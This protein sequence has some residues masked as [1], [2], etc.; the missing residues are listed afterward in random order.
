MVGNEGVDDVIRTAGGLGSGK[1]LPKWRDRGFG[2]WPR[3]DQEYM[4]RLRIVNPVRLLCAGVS[5]IVVSISLL[6]F[7]D[8]T[9]RV[10]PVVAYGFGAFGVVVLCVGIWSIRKNQWRIRE[11]KLSDPKTK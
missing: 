8:A 11:P 7:P 9:G 3:N 5:G 4:R 10:S 2:M 6:A 1:D